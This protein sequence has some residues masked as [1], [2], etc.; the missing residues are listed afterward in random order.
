MS[1]KI[2]FLTAAVTL[3]LV[4]LSFGTDQN[5]Q[6]PLPQEKL[7]KTPV[8]FSFAPNV[9]T[10]GLVGENNETNLSLNLIGG[11]NGTINGVEVG[12]VVNIVTRNVAGFQYSG[13]VNTVGGDVMGW[14][15]AG[16]CNVVNGDLY[17]Y[18]NS[19]VF[20]SAGKVY[21]HQESGVVNVAYQEVNGLQAAGITNVTP[22]TVN[23][24][25]VSGFVNTGGD[26]NGAQISGVVNIAK[27]VKGVQLGLVNISDN[28]QGVPLGLVN[29]I[30]SVGFHYQAYVDEIGAT[31]FALRNG[32]EYLY[33]LLTLGFKYYDDNNIA[34]AF[35]WGIGGRVPINEKWSANIDAIA[36]ALSSEQ[37][38]NDETDFLGKVRIGGGWQINSHVA[39]IG[40]L[41]M[42]VFM[43]EDNKGDLLPGYIADAQ[44][45]LH[46][47]TRVW[48]GAYVGLEF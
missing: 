45:H 35:G 21:G 34:C 48:P 25:Q 7:I 41:S 36:Q 1:K 29:Y 26:V 28:I 43:S 14:Q 22:G 24:M 10:G 4:S 11:T 27:N 37:Y 12:G 32:G 5:D 8:K 19:G 40:G 30:R 9:G 42:N 2:I 44:R 39:L 6:T 31:S 15:D 16:V 20:N 3:A 23:G 17:G 33:T 13:V 38:T 18:Q 46:R 47:W